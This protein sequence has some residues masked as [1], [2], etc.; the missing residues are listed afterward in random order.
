METIIAIFSVKVI[1]T[2]ANESVQLVL[3]AMI[4]SEVLIA[5]AWRMRKETEKNERTT[6]N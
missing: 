4:L 3:V 5:K 6:G 1:A 2:L